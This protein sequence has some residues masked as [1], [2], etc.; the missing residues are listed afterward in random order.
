MLKTE[1]FLV[2]QNSLS[3][4]SAQF[5]SVFLWLAFAL[6]IISIIY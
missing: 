5:F 2:D 4:Q 1:D 6:F 3:A